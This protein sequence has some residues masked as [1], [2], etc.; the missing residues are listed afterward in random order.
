MAVLN[1]V[2]LIIDNYP[3]GQEEMLQAVNNPEDETMGHRQIPFG[4]ELWIERDDFMENPPKKFFRLFPDGE[5]R[6][7][8]AYIIRCVSIE[9]DAEGNITGIHCIYYPETRSGMASEKKV[10]GT[11]HWLP[12]KHARKAETRLFDRLFAVENPDKVEEGQTFLHHINSNSLEVKEA[13]IEPTL[14]DENPLAN[15]QFERI[16]YF[17]IDKDSTSDKLIFNRTVTL[18]D[19]WAKTSSLG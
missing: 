3:D 2:K 9:K 5:V 16:G 19:S 8:Y 4:K 11:I 13:F 1:P 7:K 18:K 10:K 15:Y 14:L 12:V 17:C 6:L